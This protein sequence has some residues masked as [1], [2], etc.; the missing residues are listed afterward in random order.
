M[1]DLI[2][3]CDGWWCGRVDENVEVINWLIF[4]FVLMFDELEV[5]DYVNGN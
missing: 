5:R 4:N 2:V 3:L 1:N